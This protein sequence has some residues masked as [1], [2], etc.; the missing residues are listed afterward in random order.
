[1]LVQPAWQEGYDCVAI[2][3]NSGDRS[4]TAELGPTVRLFDGAGAPEAVHC[5]LVGW[6]FV[7]RNQTPLTRGSRPLYKI[8]DLGWERSLF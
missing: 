7:F 3:N 4:C 8:N 5:C 1:M 6:F 2:E